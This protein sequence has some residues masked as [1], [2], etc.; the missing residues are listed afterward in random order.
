MALS[1]G[2]D[3]AT[4]LALLSDEQKWDLMSVH[5]ILW[6]CGQNLNET[7]CCSMQSAIDAKKIANQL[8]SKFKVIDAQDTFKKKT[9]ANFVKYYED[10]LVPNA[11]TFCNSTTKLV[12]LFSAVDDP[13]NYNIATG[14]YARTVEFDDKV[15]IRRSK[16]LK[17]DQSYFLYRLPKNIID[18]SIFPLGDFETKEEV[19][20]IASDKNIIV[21]KKPD[22]QDL[23]FLPKEGVAAFLFDYAGLISKKGPIIFNNVVIGEHNGVW[24]KTIGQRRGF[25]LSGVSEPLF[26]SHVDVKENTIYV[27]KLD[28]IEKDEFYLNDCVL[29]LP[30]KNSDFIIQVRYHSKPILC[31]ITVLADN[32]V[33]VKLSEKTIVV[34]GQ[35]GVLYNLQNDVCF[36]GG[37]INYV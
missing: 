31:S 25:G 22:S 24:G 9:V 32:K 8:G 11:C 12:S 21:S 4:S 2:V 19:R 37:V 10:G 18:R 36:G 17:K 23:C 6:R 26:I 33:R 16:N 5:L 30:N 35:S 27:D 15:F 20:K 13:D 1:G 7:S 3:S 29:N 14:H 34:P 28:N